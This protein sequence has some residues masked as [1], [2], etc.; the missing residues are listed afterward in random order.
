MCQSP[1]AL[2]TTS[3]KVCAAQHEVKRQKCTFVKTV[4]GKK[5]MCGNEELGDMNME[6]RILCLCL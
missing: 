1:T 5:T 6:D 3:G 4:W 2:K